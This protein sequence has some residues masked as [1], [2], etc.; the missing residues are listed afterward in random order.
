M[1]NLFT[2]LIL[3]SV[4]CVSLYSAPDNASSDKPKSDQAMVL[5]FN[6]RLGTSTT[7][8]LPLYGYV[9]VTVNWGDGNEET[10]TSPGDKNHT[11]ASEG[12]Y[13]VSIEGTLEHFG[14]YTPNADKL[15]KVLSFGNLGLTNLS[16]AFY[17]ARNLN[18]V[19]AQI[20]ADVTNLSWMFYDA[21]SFNQ[22]IGGWDV[23]SVTNMSGMFRGAAS[24]N[25]DIG[26]WDVSS[27]TSMSGVFR[28]ARDFNQDIGEWDVS[29]VTWM[30]EMFHFARDL[31][32]FLPALKG[33]GFFIVLSRIARIY[34]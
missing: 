21:S 24:F 31:D 20:P 13:T 34:G 14:G 28:S 27:V 2:F 30:N 4:Y 23:S 7:I 3:I 12:T 6:T 33:A 19:P 1:K 29:N 17:R 26:G 11:Y 5:V 8:T 10:F 32:Q 25:Q 22:D 9:N 15:L 16:A 18:E